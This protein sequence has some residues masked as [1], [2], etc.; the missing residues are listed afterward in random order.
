VAAT[1]DR[2]DMRL[3]DYALR[4][5]RP[6][7]LALDRPR[8]PR[9]RHARRRTGHP[10]RYRRYR[11]PSRPDD[12]HARQWRREPRRAPGLCLRSAKLGASANL[13]ATLEGPLKDPEVGGTLAIKNGR[14]RWFSLPHALEKI[15]GAA[16]FDSR[17][18][19][20]DGLTGE[21]GG[22]AVTFGGRI[23]KEGYLLGGST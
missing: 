4:N 18:V 10:D 23:D 20:L 21:L 17:G 9:H 14:V 5:A 12:Q 15:D 22:G 2:L 8:R 16:R 3:F 13:S 6:I 1:V 7:Q 19:T 11:E